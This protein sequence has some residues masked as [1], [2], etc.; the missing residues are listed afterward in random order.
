MAEVTRA[1]EDI[2]R[3]RSDASSEMT[4][5]DAI[6]AREQYL[7]ENPHLREFQAEIDATLRNVVGFENRMVVLGLMM[8]ARMYQLKAIIAGLLPDK[9]APFGTPKPERD[10]EGLLPAARRDLH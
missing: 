6:E 4:L 8:E 10:T 3:R 9:D 2:H 1:S 5:D 7:R